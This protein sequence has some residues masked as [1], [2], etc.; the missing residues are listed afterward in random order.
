MKDT[1]REKPDEGDVQF[2]YAKVL[3]FVSH[4]GMVFIAAGYLIYVMQLP[5]LSVSI[6]AVADNWH[7][8]ASDMQQKLHVP[9][10]W[11]FMGSMAD[12]LHG[13]VVSYMSILFLCM[14]TILCLVFAVKVFFRE[15]NYIYTAITFLQA[16]VLLVAASGV[17]SR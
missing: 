4:A 12:A 11:S 17:I 14:A 1:N 6:R 2:V 7:L 3:D 16:L 15:K 13:D 10:G 5:P 8:S 9:S